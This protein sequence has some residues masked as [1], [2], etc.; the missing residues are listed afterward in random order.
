MSR[1]RIVTGIISPLGVGGI[2]ELGGSWSITFQ[3][4]VWR[5]AGGP[6]ET[7]PLRIEK[8]IL[9]EIFFTL[10]RWRLR[11]GQTIRLRV[12]EMEK[13][14]HIM[15]TVEMLGLQGRPRDPEL[16]EAAHAILNPA[17]ITHPKLGILKASE[18]FHDIYEAEG[19]WCGI[20]VKLALEAGEHSIEEA[21][22]HL[23]NALQRQAEIDALFRQR[24]VDDYYD[25]W[26]E[27]WAREGEYVDRADWIARI[28]PANV[29]MDGSGAISIYY[30]DGDLFAG[31]SLIASMSPDGEI[32]EA[33]LVG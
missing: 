11:K 18:T 24:I 33:M 19:E 14:P 27:G 1:E 28:S 21:A 26:A 31:H 3:L 32:E 23:Y 29:D 6:I 2:C 8:P 20:P 4:L 12:Q 5:E 13:P 16:A 30:D 9:G 25:I 10:W 15:R 7:K 17:D 22:D